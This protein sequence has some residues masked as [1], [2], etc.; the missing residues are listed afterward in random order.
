MIV[1]T[2]KILLEEAA[3]WHGCIRNGLYVRQGPLHKFPDKRRS[4]SAQRQ[5]CCCAQGRRQ[6]R[7]PTCQGALQVGLCIRGAHNQVTLHIDHDPLAWSLEQEDK[8][9][10]PRHSVLQ[11]VL[12]VQSLS[13]ERSPSPCTSN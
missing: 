6:L 8:L 10:R 4:N 1:N 5:P 12:H 7:L 11:T 13:E 3:A 2:S 9:G